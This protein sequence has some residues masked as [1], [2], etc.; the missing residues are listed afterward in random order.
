MDP[1]EIV[2][3][4][5]ALS[6]KSHEEKLWCVDDTLKVSV[7]KK[8]DLSLIG[9]VIS[10]KHVNRDVF[11]AV[12]PRVWQLTLDIEVVKD[13][14]FLF[15]FC[16]QGDRFRVLARGPWSFDNYLPVLE[17]PSGV[18]DITYLSF[19]KMV[20]WIQILNAPLLCMTREM[21]EFLGKIIGDFKDI[22]VGVTG[23]CFRKYM[24]IKVAIDISKPLKCK[25]ILQGGG[26]ACEEGRWK[27]LAREGNRNVATSNGM[28]GVGKRGLSDPT[29]LTV[30][31]AVKKSKRKTKFTTVTDEISVGRVI[32]S[33][34]QT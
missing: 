30:A 26:W 13:N 25:K 6:I 2:K 11:R 17:K 20:F 14:T 9:K 27:Q 21:G 32:F 15:Y 23:E 4:Y 3:L 10:N 18:G 19:H 22:G 29:I 5:A 1:E 31:P 12:I 34:C 8:L 7:G 33:A 16:N 24:R 28:A